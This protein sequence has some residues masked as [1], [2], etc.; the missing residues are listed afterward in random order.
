MGDDLEESQISLTKMFDEQ[1][2]YY[3][4]IGMTYNEFWQE[5]P[6]RVIAYREAHKIKTEIKKYEMWEQGGYFYESLVNTSI[7]FRD[8]VKSGK[9][10]PYP[11]KP[12]GVSETQKTEH[13]IQ[14]QQENERLKAKIHFDMLFKNIS[15]RFENEAGENNE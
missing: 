1:C 15:K 8:L 10:Q 3:L 11:E 7:L 4:A 5:N 2:P 14:E 9:A 6:F 12:Y 13:E